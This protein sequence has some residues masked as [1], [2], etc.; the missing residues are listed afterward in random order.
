MKAIVLSLPKTGTHTL[1]EAYRRL[2]QSVFHMDQ[3]P[4]EDQPVTKIPNLPMNFRFQEECGPWQDFEGCDVYFTQAKVHFDSI[5]KRHPKAFL[6]DCPRDREEWI[7]SCLAH[8]WANRTGHRKGRWKEVS[9]AELC[10][11]WDA[12]K[13][14]IE[15]I[16]QDRKVIDI[17]ICGA[18]WSWEK[19]AK[20][21]GMNGTDCATC[22]GNTE[23]RRSQ[24]GGCP[25]CIGTGKLNEWS[26]PRVN[27]HMVD[28]ES[29]DAT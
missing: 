21:V 20:S 3:L 28:P 15:E 10:G 5:I 14:A 16:R 4:F 1:A 12:H 7:S 23:N 9:T 27:V 18:E 24:P 26:V 13:E 17:P 19:V 8:V 29:N 2:G 25:P 11:Q 22:G 6:I